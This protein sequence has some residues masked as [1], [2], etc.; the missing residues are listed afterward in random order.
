MRKSE[1]VYKIVKDIPK[2]KVMTYGQVGKIAGVSPRLVGKILH[3]NPDPENIPCHRVVNFKG[4]L[5]ESYAFGGIKIQ[6]KKLV[7]E[8]VRVFKGRIDLTKYIFKRK[9]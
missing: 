3:D 6:S 4:K 5:S 9:N 8:D 7:Q 2:G 1:E